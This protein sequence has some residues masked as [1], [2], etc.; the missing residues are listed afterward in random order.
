MKNQFLSKVFTWFGIGLLVTFLTAYLTST[1]INALRFIFNGSSYIIIVILEFVIAI[2]LSARIHTMSTSLA[3]GLYIGYSALT[4]L[5]FSSIF[6]VYEITSILWIFL[7]SAFVFGIFALL[8]KSNKFDLSKYG[9][10]LI[11]ALLGSV[12]LEIIN[13]FLANGTLDIILCV[14]V[15]AIF[16]TYVAYDVQKIINRYDTTEN[17]AIYG[18]FDLYLDFINIFLRL[19]QLFGKERD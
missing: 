5:T 19:L 12:I 3:K 6:I 9:I 10:Y 4:G 11:I 14:F 2:W 7:A 1:N 17:M 8:G 15:L 18:A 16:V 13:I